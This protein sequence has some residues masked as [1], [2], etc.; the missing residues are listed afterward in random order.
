MC[1]VWNFGTAPQRREGRSISLTG[2]RS[3]HL[4]QNE[5]GVAVG[6][7]GRDASLLLRD[8]FRGILLA[9]RRSLNPPLVEGGWREA[10]GGCF[11][12]LILER[13]AEHRLGSLWLPP[14][15][16]SCQATKLSDK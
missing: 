8:N 15:G 6:D 5:G 10:P 1:G 13:G 7:G 12:R 3:L 11:R 14:R 4:P 16:G 9:I 2:A